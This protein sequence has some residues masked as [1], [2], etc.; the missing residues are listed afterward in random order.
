[1]F[2][3]AIRGRLFATE[4]FKGQDLFNLVIGSGRSDLFLYTIQPFFSSGLHFLRA[5]HL[6]VQCL[7]IK[8]LIRH[9]LILTPVPICRIQEVSAFC[10]ARVSFWPY[11]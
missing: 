11:N 10:S 4:H 6:S 9:R 8:F 3:S 7:V 5:A 2:E 1:M